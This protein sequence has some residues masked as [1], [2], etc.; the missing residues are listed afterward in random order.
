VYKRQD[1]EAMDSMGKV[2]ERFTGVRNVIA[3]SS[4]AG[5]LSEPIWD[6]IRENPMQ[7]EIRRLLGYDDRFML[8]QLRISL[9]EGA[10]EANEEE[11]LREQ[12]SEGEIERCRGLTH[13]KRRLEWLAG[14]IVAKGVVRLYLDFKAPHPSAIKV[15]SSP[16]NVPYVVIEGEELASS[17]PHISISHSGDIAVAVA[18]QGPG[19]GIDVEKIAG[20]ILEIAD[21]FSTEKEVERVSKFAGLNRIIALM[22]I[23]VIK[24]AARKAVGPG[25][26]SM[27]DLVLE[28]VEEH[29][30]YIVCELYHTNTG[31]IKSVTFQSSEYIYAVSM[32]L[33]QGGDGTA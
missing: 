17:I 6:S 8:A 28:K 2:V 23:W 26:C 27:K 31:R 15:E 14:R 30:N 29:G 13:P 19:V 5:D 1:I 33:N 25:A 24:E 32:S 18:S 22:S 3:G 9:V 11:L 10:A 4:D 12:L 21:K 7:T 20:S 16:D